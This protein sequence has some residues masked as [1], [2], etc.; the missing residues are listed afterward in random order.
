MNEIEEKYLKFALDEKMKQM[1]CQSSIGINGQDHKTLSY[2]ITT[3]EIDQKGKLTT[4]EKNK[5]A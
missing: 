2:V 4:I 5:D 3:I 1:F